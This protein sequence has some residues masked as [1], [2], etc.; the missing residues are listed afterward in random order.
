MTRNELLSQVQQECLKFNFPTDITE[1]FKNLKSD[2]T[3]WN[4]IRVG[5]NQYQNHDNELLYDLIHL[6]YYKSKKSFTPVFKYDMDSEI[7]DATQPR[8]SLGLHSKF[9]PLSATIINR[10]LD[11]VVVSDYPETIKRVVLSSGVTRAEIK[12]ISRNESCLL[13]SKKYL[14]QNYLVS[15]TIDFHGQMPGAYNMLS[16][17]MVKLALT[18]RPKTFFGL[19]CVNDL[20]EM[21]YVSKQLSLDKGLEGLKN[22]LLM[23]IDGHKKRARYQFGKFDYAEQKK[24]LQSMTP[25]DAS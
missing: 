5:T 6:V 4:A 23:L 7:F 21:T 12:I 8:L 2:N 15:S 14:K 19:N 18:L 22:E 1:I 9:S 24:M 20:G 17:S 11:F 16:D 25:H 3:I 13:K 10:G